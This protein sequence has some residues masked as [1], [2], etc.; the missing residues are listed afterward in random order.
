[1]GKDTKSFLD[2]EAINPGPIDSIG[3]ELTVSTSSNCRYKAKRVHIVMDPSLKHKERS[4]K[5]R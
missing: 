5:R 2:V 3:L 1:M 4:L